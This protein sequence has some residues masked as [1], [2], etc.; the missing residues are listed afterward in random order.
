MHC[1]YK[2]VAVFTFVR[3]IQLR[4]RITKQGLMVIHFFIL[5]PARIS[6]PL[7]YGISIPWIHGYM[8]LYSDARIFLSCP[9]CGGGSVYSLHTHVRGRQLLREKIALV[10]KGEEDKKKEL[11][12]VMISI[13]VFSVFFALVLFF[14][15]SLE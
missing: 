4:I 1:S 11:K 5:G 7:W 14:F 13:I 8:E 15:Y 2:Y 9:I 6:I 10:K 12:R 3:S